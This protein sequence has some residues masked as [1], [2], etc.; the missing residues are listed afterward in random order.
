M[1]YNRPIV[2]SIAGFDPTGGAGLLADVKT[3]E[4]LRCLGMGVLTANTNQTEADFR[5]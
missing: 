4:Q 2:L 5:S 3:C 1:N